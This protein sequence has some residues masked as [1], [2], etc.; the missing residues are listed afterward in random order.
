M[1]DFIRVKGAREH[2]LKDVSLDIPKNKLVVF[3]GL[4]GSGKSSLAFD[5]I[6][7]EG[8]RRY[9]ESLSSY[10]RQFLGVMDKPD[11]DSIDGLSPAISID[12]KSTSH[13]PRSTVGT[14]TEIYDYLRL[15]FARIGHP[16]CPIC[17]RE[18]AKQS[19][20]Q[21]VYAMLRLGASS[22]KSENRKLFPFL[23]LSPVVRDRRGEF[24]ALFD[25]LRAKGY[26]QVRVDGQIIDL[27]EDIVLIKT[28]KHAIDVVVDRISIDTATAKIITRVVDAQEGNV[29]QE[30]DLAFSSIRSRLSDAVEQAL[31]LSEGLVII[32]VVN[33]PGFT[34][35]T[36]P[37]KFTDHI[38][39]EKFSCPVDNISIPE[40]EPR[41][42]SFNSPHGACPT[43]SGIGS[44]LTVD[45]NLVMNPELSVSEGGIIPFAKMFF[46]DTWFS[47]I[48]TFVAESNGINLRKPLKLTTDAQRHVLLYGTG[49]ELHKVPGTNRLGEMTTI[50][51]PYHGIIG[52]LK[53]RYL[54]SDSEYMRTEIEKF[55]RQE[56]C[57]T[58]EGKRLKKEALTITVQGNSIAWVTNLSINNCLDWMK[59]L[60]ENPKHELSEQESVISKPI[61]KE[62]IT[63]LTFLVS[64][65]LD[66]L[67][68]GR[69]ATTLAGGEAQR[70]RLASQIGSGLSGVL[71]VL[72]EPSIGLHQRDNN[73]LIKTLKTLRDL[74][75]TVI[76]VEHD[77]EMM[78]ES[79]YIFDIGPGAGEHG[80][81][82]IA[83]GT[84][85]EILKNKHS[86]TAPY[87]L[88]RKSI[89][90]P[91]QKALLED[92][93]KHSLLLIGAKEN[94]LKN[95]TA[96]FPL[97]KF[98][99]V[100]GVSGSGKSTLIV[101]TLYPAL[102][103][104]YS[105]LS[106]ARPGKFDR[107]EGLEYVNR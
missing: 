89:T 52:E 84:I 63:R 80:G 99:C 70:I 50:T 23:V 102:Q 53:K 33:D 75:N 98:I 41:S 57:Q 45:P 40:I 34:I 94:N 31:S 20:Q 67:T 43:C 5:T 9:V 29:S 49:E 92:T 85:A 104:H 16:H 30:T 42:F 2:N 4:S 61:L 17:G 15:L 81:Q 27:D 18:I 55:M 3:T 46:H 68:L 48:V 21:I 19:S 56:I 7:A 44:I 106:K 69:T 107:M 105:P 36:K 25:N 38:F 8:Q 1:L 101:E 58:C 87:L 86:V 22:L 39:S 71:Y 90:R 96:S 54:E 47:R 78:E 95:I 37:K 14:V 74:G 24:T 73:R 51:E 88:D 72:D 32:G 65:G 100:T 64:V 12:Q 62:I 82:I 76:V 66:Y 26:R 60:L 97:G 11:V 59:E 103:N 6:Y 77:R 93:E 91:K 13:N 35:P 10:A 79:D 83:Q 28:N